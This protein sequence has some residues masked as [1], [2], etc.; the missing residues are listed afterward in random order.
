MNVL[1]EWRVQQYP[2]SVPT[3]AQAAITSADGPLSRHLEM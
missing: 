3:S 2:E 1:Q